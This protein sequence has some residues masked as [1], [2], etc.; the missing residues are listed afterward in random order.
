MGDGMSDD[1]NSEAPPRREVPGAGGA[2]PEAAADAGAAGAGPAERPVSSRRRL[3]SLVALVVRLLLVVL[4]LLSAYELVAP[5][6]FRIAPGV[7]TIRVAP[8]LGGGETIVPLGPV[9]RIRF[10]THSS[11]VNVEVSFVF[12]DTP[13]IESEARALLGDLPSVGATAADALRAYALGKIVWVCVLGLVAGALVAGIG[14][15]RLR[16]TAV[17]AGI[18]LAALWIVVGSV[19]G[20]TYSG[21]NRQPSATFDGL[22]RYAPRIISLLQDVVQH[23]EAAKWSVDDLA[24]GLE[25]VARQASTTVPVG[26][27]GD[28]VVRLLVAG[29]LHDNV[30]GYRLVRRLSADPRLAVA[31]VILVGDLTH[32]GTEPEAE[33][34]L[35]ELKPVEVPIA[36]V[37]GNHENAPAMRAFAGAGII[38]LARGPVRLAGLTIMGFDDPL[39]GDLEAL[40]DVT[41]RNEAAAAA[42]AAVRAEVPAPE[43]VVFHDVGQAVD[44]IAWAAEQG[45]PLTVLHGHDHVT[46][47]ERKDSVIILDPGSGGASGY[48]QLGRDPGTPYTFQL[49]E[50]VLDPEPHPIAVVTLEY[51]GLAGASS[52]RYQPL[53]PVVPA[54]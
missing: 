42:L 15:G 36:M 18:G 28:D 35:G 4:A 17:G 21:L 25:E 40:T 6:S 16:R 3:R 31:G 1:T 32:A 46:S 43:V 33:L 24:R 41:Q 54:E 13:A 45:L 29:D 49:V 23:P 22:A 30:I 2:D 8:A 39:A 51:E 12:D 48:E 47:V 19:A 44:V 9:G 52:A 11:P 14:C 27:E 5:E 38:Q 37:G 20:V 10:D 26:S 7:A 50:F 53:E 34:V